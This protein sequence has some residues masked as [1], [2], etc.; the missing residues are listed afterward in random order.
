MIGKGRH[1][2]APA[3]SPSG[4]RD[5]MAIGCVGESTSSSPQREVAVILPSA[6]GQDE[7]GFRFQ[8]VLRDGSPRR[9][10]PGVETPGYFHASFPDEM[11]A[12]SRRF[13]PLLAIPALSSPR[14]LPGHPSP[15]CYEGN[16]LN[17]CLG[18]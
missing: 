3:F 2:E 16:L 13:P 8:P 4:P 14:P 10:V 7:A 17:C 9:R 6:C 15:R 1:P 18:R 11:R 12:D 5:L